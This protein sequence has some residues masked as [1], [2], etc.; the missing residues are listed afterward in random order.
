VNNGSIQVGGTFLCSEKGNGVNEIL[1]QRSFLRCY[2]Q[3]ARC[4][5][6]IHF[7][8]TFSPGDNISIALYS[9]TGQQTFEK[10][11]TGEEEFYLAGI[12][13]GLYFI[14]LRKNSEVKEYGKLMIIE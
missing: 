9:L 3:P 11:F 12:S 14:V 7:E 13:P 2:P 1:A 5:E 10:T 8:E 6:P 4:G